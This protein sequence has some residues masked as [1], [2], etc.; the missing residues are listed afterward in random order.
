MQLGRDAER[1]V[2][3]DGH[4]RVDAVVAERL[5]DALDPVLLLGGIRPRGAEDGA[6][7]REDAADVGRRELIDE[8]LF[9][10]PGPAVL[11]AT[12]L[13]ST[14]ERAAGDGAD[15]GVEPGRVSTAGQDSNPHGK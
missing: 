9:E 14:L 5:D 6:A 10:A 15:G 4:E 12:D 1:V 11:H 13:V 2:A 8:A 7:Q 3:S